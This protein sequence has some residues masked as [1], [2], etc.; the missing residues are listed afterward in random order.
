LVCG[1]NLKLTIADDGH[2]FKQIGPIERKRIV[3]KLNQTGD[4]W[5]VSADGKKYNV[6]RL[7]HYFKGQADNKVTVIVLNRRV[8]WAAMKCHREEANWM[9]HILW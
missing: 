4:N 6:Y 1:D 7:R 2:Y 5:I 8:Y 3:G 9:Y